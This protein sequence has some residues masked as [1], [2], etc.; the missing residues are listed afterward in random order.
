M[1]TESRCAFSRMGKRRITSFLQSSRR[2]AAHVDSPFDRYTLHARIAPIF[3]TLI[4]FSFAVAVWFPTASAVWNYVGTLLVTFPVSA[5]LAQLGR[6][7]GKRKEPVLFKRWGGTP[8][9]RLLSHRLSTLNPITLRRYHDKLASLLPDLMIPEP[10]DEARNTT[11][12]DQIYESCVHFLR[13]STRDRKQFPLVFAENVNYGFRRNLWAL[14]PYGIV[15]AI[16]GIVSCGLFLLNRQHEGNSSIGVVGLLVSAAL[17]ALW[18]FV[19]N[20]DW[21]RTIAYTYAERLLAVL[22]KM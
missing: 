18:I 16:I 4:P 5:L 14:K 20:P 12:T 11:S 13:E 22:D 17:F 8:T 1:P 6:E 2:I 3:V 15:S 10:L 9:T 19:F 7:L 21:V